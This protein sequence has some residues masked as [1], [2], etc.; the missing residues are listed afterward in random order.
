M[1]R[2]SGAKQPGTLDAFNRIGVQA[3]MWNAQVLRRKIRGW[4]LQ[5]SP[6]E[7]ATLDQRLPRM[8]EEAFRQLGGVSEEILYDLD[9]FRRV[10]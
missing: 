6:D 4:G 1:G 9:L 3:G 8:L 10:A 2:F 5:P 7:E